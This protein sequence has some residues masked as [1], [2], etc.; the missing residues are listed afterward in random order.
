MGSVIVTIIQ[1]MILYRL[2]S[3]ITGYGMVGL[4]YLLCA[5]FVAC[6]YIIFDTQ[7]IVEKAE[8]GDKDV[9]THTMMLFVDLFELFIRIL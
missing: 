1:A 2:M 7:V 6:L 8:R 4:P 3:W 5:L 9:P